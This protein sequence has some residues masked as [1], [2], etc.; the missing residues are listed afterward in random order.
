MSFS[1]MKLVSSPFKKKQ[2]RDTTPSDDIMEIVFK[3]VGSYHNFNHLFSVDEY[4]EVTN[5]YCNINIYRGYRLLKMN[6]VDLRGMPRTDYIGLLKKLKWDEEIR[7][8]VLRCNGDKNFLKPG[9][10]VNCPLKVDILKFYCMFFT[11]SYP[12]PQLWKL[13][14]GW[15]AEQNTQKPKKSKTRP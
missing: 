6:K 12:N 11:C 4:L 7:L 13:I 8:L 5:V 15:M 14:A 10:L 1:K 3:S 9:T 2:K